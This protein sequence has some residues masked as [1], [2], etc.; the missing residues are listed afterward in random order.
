VILLAVFACTG[1]VETDT[2]PDAWQL[3]EC[4]GFGPT[5]V[6]GQLANPSIDE[7]SGIV[8]SPR[9]T[10]AY[11]INND[12]GDSARLFAIDQTGADLG[13]WNINSASAYD[14][15]DIAALPPSTLIA[16]DIGDN[17]SIRNDVTLYLIDEPENA[18]GGGSLD[19]TAHVLVYPDGAHNAETL[20]ADPLTGA[21]YIVTKHSSNEESIVFLA[22]LEADTLTEVARIDV[23]VT[24]GGDVRADGQW[25]AISTYI[26]AWGWARN[27]DEPLHTAFERWP[28]E[29][30]RAGEAQGEAIAWTPEDGLLTVSEGAGEDMH[31]SPAN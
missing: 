26:D 22:D 4:L 23:G 6:T 9:G 24:T 25:I 3:P 31:L 30:P 21:V 2:D 28:C 19:A 11:W 1:T 13:V 8:A 29:L 12:S 14:W 17:D 16:A 10:G 20:I 15:E 5:T 27:P 7:A 18:S